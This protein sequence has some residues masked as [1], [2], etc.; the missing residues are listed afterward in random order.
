MIF[1]RAEK[2]RITVLLDNYYSGLMPQ[3]A[4]VTR[5]G[6][7]K[8]KKPLMAG[9]GFS[10]L[11]EAIKGDKIQRLLFDSGHSPIF[12]RNNIE[13]L[14]I[15]VTEIE[16]AMLSH[17]HFDHFMGFYE[18][19]VMRNGKK[20]PLYL[21]PKAF[22]KK[23]LKFPDGRIMELPQLD[24]NKL[25]ELGAIIEEVELPTVVNEFFVISGEI[26]R[27]RD[28]EKPW[29]LARVLREDGSDVV[30][31]FIDEMALGIVIAGKGLAVIS[32][33]SHPGIINTIDHLENITGEKCCFVIGGFHLE[34]TESETVIKTAVTL[35]EKN[36][37]MV[38]PCHC[39]GF[40]PTVEIYRTVGD[41]FVPSCVGTTFEIGEEI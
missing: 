6:P 2:V 32:G 5:P 15:D 41:K 24:R 22:T 10:L 33:C 35:R 12:I 13:A 9:H 27:K 21:H 14:S 23:V 25:E 7:G 40:Y 8:Q 26:E 39:T 16:C 18:V 4:G 3:R 37:E 1:E 28:F 38:V 30:D 19:L 29:P 11:V 31:Y 20:L 36:I 34:T 17:G